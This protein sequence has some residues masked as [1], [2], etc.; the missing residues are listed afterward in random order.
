MN[1]IRLFIKWSLA[2][3]IVAS[4]FYST[5]VVVYTFMVDGPNN[6]EGYPQGWLALIFIIGWPGSVAVMLLCV[7]AIVALL[8]TSVNWIIHGQFKYT[9]E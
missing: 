7:G 1:Y 3:L 8:I 5:F 2:A 4:S 9:I 6:Y